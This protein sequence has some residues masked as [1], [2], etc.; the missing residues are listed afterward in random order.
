MNI[1]IIELEDGILLQNLQDFELR[2]TFDC[3]QCFRFNEDAD[4]SFI[5]IADGRIVRMIKQ[6]MDLRIKGAKRTDADFWLDFLDLNRDYSRIKAQLSDDPILKE[7]IRHGLGIRILN[8][9]P[10]ETLISFIISANKQIKQIKRCVEAIAEKFGEPVSFEGKTYYS[11]PDAM[12]L[13]KA[14][15]AELRTCGCGYRA[16]YIAATAADLAAGRASLD[17]IMA[18]ELP[19]AAKA[20][21]QLSGV[22]P[23]VAD[24]ILLFAMKKHGAFPVD[25]WVKRVLEEFYFVEYSNLKELRAYGMN[26]FG[27]NAGIAQQY[28]FYYAREMKLR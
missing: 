16:G 2:H 28:L 23:K 25:V 11:F 8:Q 3:G 22:G 27:E 1:E 20:L 15:E 9:Q 13:S 17:E 12:Q 14:G 7:A 18:Q 4:G 6:G 24:C 10:F 5:G 26:Q 19:A 21:Q